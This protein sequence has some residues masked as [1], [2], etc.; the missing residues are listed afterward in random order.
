MWIVCVILEAMYS[1]WHNYLF[2]LLFQMLAIRFG[3]KSPSSGQCLKNL[4]MLV[5]I[6]GITRQYHGIPF[7]FIAVLYNWYRL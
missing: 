2:I 1:A 7:T 3:L 4:K 5:H 6:L